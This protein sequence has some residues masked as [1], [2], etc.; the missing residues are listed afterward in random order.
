MTCGFEPL[1]R[2]RC[3][4]LAAA[5]IVLTGG[6]ASAS[7]EGISVPMDEAG[8]TDYVAN[9]M[10][11]AM[12]NQKVSIGGPLQVEV[13]KGQEN[14][15]TLDL[16]GIYR[17]CQRLPDLCAQAIAEHVRKMAPVVA[18]AALKPEKNTLRL[19]V[20]PEAYVQ[21]LQQAAKKGEPA[22]EPLMDGLWSVLVFDTP[23]AIATVTADQ[24]AQLGLTREAAISVAKANL[25]EALPS[26][27]SAARKAKAKEVG[28]LTG[29][30]YE[31]SLFLFPDS[32][33]PLAKH[34]K[35]KLIVAIPAS[36][37]MLFAKEIAP[38]AAPALAE[39]ARDVMSKSRRPIS[40][41]VFR[42]S[43]DGWQLARKG[44]TSG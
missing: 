39:V 25:S 19:I 16:G 35:G 42:W 38:D 43:S 7:S 3:V 4:C 6:A 33:A 20:R 21:Q 10:V 13:N 27:K 15:H 24:L 40:D 2:L 34:M 44:R 26:L 8:F 37:V 17:Y 22:V 41:A 11:E 5:A 9:L 28:L 36:D 14:W 1:W 30:P 31:S 23:T 32:W 29:D 18:G 12:P